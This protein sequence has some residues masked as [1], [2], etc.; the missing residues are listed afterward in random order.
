MPHSTGL[1][2][3][4]SWR[5]EAV[6]SLA[7]LLAGSSTHVGA[8]TR[9]CARALTTSLRVSPSRSDPPALPT[10]GGFV[11]SGAGTSFVERVEA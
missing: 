9:G 6:G 4:P 5:A 10:V 2:G 11:A 1:P 8:A 3:L 7:R